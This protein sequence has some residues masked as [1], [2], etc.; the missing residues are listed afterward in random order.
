MIEFTVKDVVL[1]D[2][3]IHEIIDRIFSDNVLKTIHGQNTEISPWKQ[4]RREVKYCH[5]VSNISHPFKKFVIKDKIWVTAQQVLHFDAAD[6][7]QARMENKVKLKCVGSRFISINSI[8]RIHRC[9][10]TDNNMF[11]ANVRVNVA[12]PGIANMTEH[13]LVDQ[14]KDEVERFVREIRVI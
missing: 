14:A 9:E 6:D 12:L 3:S 1:G 10:K 8:F 11:E 4:N 2:S 13:L 7:K 5:D